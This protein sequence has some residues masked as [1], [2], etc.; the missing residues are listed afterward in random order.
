MAPD[1]FDVVII[2][3]FHHAAAPTYQA[4]LEHLQPRELIGLTATPERAD[5]LPV[6]HWFDDRIA[7]ELRLWDAID[8]QRLVP[9][10]YYGIH[11]GVDLRDIPWRRGQ[12]YDTTALSNVYTSND[13]WVRLVYNHLVEHVDDV[14]TMRCFGFCVGV[15]HAEYMAEQFSRLGVVAV[16]L[17]GNSS[18]EERSSALRRLAEGSVQVVFTVD[19]FNEGVD[20]PSV[21]T[22]LMLRPT[23]SATLFLQQLGR[24]LRKSVGKSAC[25]VLDFVGTH[26]QEFRF[27][28]RYR[29][30][31]G[32]TQEGPR[33][34]GEGGLPVPS[35]RMPSA[36]GPRRL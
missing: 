16:A 34:C 14:S 8:Q 33:K 15:R 25:T 11:D 10:A 6:L 28:L 20:V 18:D 29:G 1:H 27:D 36:P 17:S 5:G 30:L 23:E 22:I 9:F 24:G 13:A 19:L 21:D 12:G 7:A 32:G 35:R 3:E 31:L 2:D 26:R 4:L